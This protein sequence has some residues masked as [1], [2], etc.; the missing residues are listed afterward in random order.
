MSFQHACDLLEFCRKH[1]DVPL[2]VH[3]E[4]GA[5]RSVAA[6]IFVAAWLKRPLQLTEVDVLNPNPWVILQLRL[7]ALYLGLKRLD[8]QLLKISLIGPMPFRF[9]VLPRSIAETYFD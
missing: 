2:M 3:C 7:A 6:G 4:A 1:R 9:N 8:R 5:S